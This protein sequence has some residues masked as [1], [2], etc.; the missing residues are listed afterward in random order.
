[1]HAKVFP[2]TFL[3]AADIHNLYLVGNLFFLFDFLSPN[4]LIG[5]LTMS[6]ILNWIA[7][8]KSGWSL[9]FYL[10]P[11]QSQNTMCYLHFFPLHP[12][13]ACVVYFP[14]NL[15]SA[16][17]RVWLALLLWRELMRQAAGAAQNTHTHT[18]EATLVT[19]KASQACRA[20]H[21]QISKIWLQL[22]WW[23]TFTMSVCEGAQMWNW[24]SLCSHSRNGNPVWCT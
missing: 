6:S 8:S 17:L 3:H 12:L 23:L 15:G 7:L 14:A 18:S 20:R 9:F 10:H 24:G 11:W 13:S 22:C 4:H 2:I 19:P 16:W 5:V 21:S 1:M